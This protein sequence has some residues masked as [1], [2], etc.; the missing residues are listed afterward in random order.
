LRE[1]RFRQTNL[2]NA[3][4]ESADLTQANFYGAKMWSVNLAGAKLLQTH[5]TNADLSEANLFGATI[6]RTGF[7]Q[8]IL[9]SAV[10]DNY[11]WLARL[12]SVGQDS[13]RGLNY[14]ISNYIVDSV[15][16]NLRV[17]YL[18]LSKRKE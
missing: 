16:T 14:L 18:L 12:P 17:Q 9:D 1:A 2:K 8:A 11:E 3:Y 15:Q 5:F 6:Q 4:L 13:V 10:V 7:D